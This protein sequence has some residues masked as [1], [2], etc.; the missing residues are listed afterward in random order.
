MAQ[1]VGFRECGHTLIEMIAVIVII[2]ILAAAVALRTSATSDRA[3]IN[4]ADQLR[5]D[6][7]H[8]Q[9]L[10]LSWGVG[11]RLAIA[12]DGAGYSVVC[13]DATLAG[14]PCAA[15][16]APPCIGKF[17]DT[18]KCFSIA[19]SATL[20]DGVK[21]TPQGGMMYFDSLGRPLTSAGVL[22]T[23][24]PASTYT[25]TGGATSAAVTVWPITGFAQAS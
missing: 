20:T 16:T 1:R 23:G 19:Y 2:G 10:A 5:R 25:L 6:I 14:T 11:L 8:I 17:P 9:V 12:S 4:Q 22:V 13:P 24:N 7:A 18:G 21:M 15:A 3:A